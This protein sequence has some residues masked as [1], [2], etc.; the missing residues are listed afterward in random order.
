MSPTHYPHVILAFIPAE[1]LICI[2][3]YQACYNIRLNPSR[4]GMR[5]RKLPHNR[6][7]VTAAY[8]PEQDSEQ[9]G[10][11]ETIHS[12][13]NHCRRRSWYEIDR[14]VRLRITMTVYWHASAEYRI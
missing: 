6:F 4:R 11:A 3:M 10:E 13:L 8:F 7:I 9:N 12:R 14:L 5:E 2:N 1:S